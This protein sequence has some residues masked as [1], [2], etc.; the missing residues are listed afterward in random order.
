MVAAGLNEVV[1]ANYCSR[2]LSSN[3]FKQSNIPGGLK[4]KIINVQR[5]SAEHTNT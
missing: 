1:V 4:I 5:W 2:W 3:H